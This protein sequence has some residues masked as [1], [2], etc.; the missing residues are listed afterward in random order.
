MPTLFGSGWTTYH[1]LRFID[2][3]AARSNGEQRLRG[4]LVGL[5]RRTNFDGMN[6]GELHRYARE[7]L[8]LIRTC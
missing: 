7:K 8:E 4:Y 5:A 2:E 6:A 3:L 1:E